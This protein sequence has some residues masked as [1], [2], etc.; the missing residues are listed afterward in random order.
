[1]WETSWALLIL[2]LDDNIRTNNTHFIS[3]IKPLPVSNVL[4][5]VAWPFGSTILVWQVSWW[6]CPYQCKQPAL[7]QAGVCVLYLGCA[8]FWSRARPPIQVLRA[9]CFLSQV[10]AVHSLP[11]SQSKVTLLKPHAPASLLSK[12]FILCLILLCIQSNQ[13]I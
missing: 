12:Y 10:L 5:F 4:K 1:M 3:L 6:L 2:Q 7:H 9:F 13:A 11:N 8:F